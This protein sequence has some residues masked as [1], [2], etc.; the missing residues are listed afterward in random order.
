[1]ANTKV[2]GDLIAS[3]TIATGNIADNAVTSDKISGITTAHITEGSNLYYTD[4]RADARVALIV[5]SS[6][7]TLNTL[8]ELAA[9]LGDDPNY[10]A[11]TATTIGLKAP[12][13][14]PSFTGDVG[15]VT[16]HSSGKFAVMS[17]SVHGSY[18]FYNNGTSY[19]NGAVIIDSNITQ[20]GA[21]IASFT[22]KVGVG[23]ADPYAFDTTATK[24][25]VKNPGSAGSVVEVAR[26][27][28]S[29]DADGS[30]AVVRIGTSNDRGMYFQAGRTGSVPYGII[31]TTEY[32]GAK[33]SSIYLQNT[34]NVGIGQAPS[35]FANWRIFEIK[36][37]SN[38][39]LINFEN[40]SSTRTGAIAMN[41]ASSLMRF[42]T[43]TDADITFEANNAERMRVTGDG[44]VGIAG[45]PPTNGYTASGGG[46]KMLQIG[47]SSQIAAYGTDDEIGIFQNTYLNS[48][49][50]FQAITSNVAGSSIIL[51]DGK[52]YFK[53]AATSGTA[54][55]T[56][57]SMF[58][59][60]TG[61]VGI[62]T[63]SPLVRLQ[64]ERTVSN[65]TSRTAPVNL[66]YLTSEHPSVG[67]TGF[68]TAIAHYSRTYQNSTK[69]EQSKIA[70]T[71]Q[72]DS[73]STSGS[74]ID[75]YTK[76]LSTGS[77]APEFRM[78]I[79]YNGNVGIGTASPYKK[80][81]VV[82]DLQLD[83]SNANMW[84][85]SGAAGTN[86]FINWTFNSDDTVYNKIGIDYDTRASTGFHIDT[87]YP[88]TLDCTTYIDF[89]RSGGTLGRWNSTGLGIGTTSPNA[90]L[91]VKQGHT[92]LGGTQNNYSENVFTTKLGGYGVLSTGTDRYGSYGWLAFNSNNNYTGGAR[93]F[94]FTNGYKANEFAL[95][96]GTS[97]QAQ[98]TLGATGNVA[99][100]QLVFH[101][102]SSADFMFGKVAGDGNGPHLQ[103]NSY[104]YSTTFQ[105][106]STANIVTYKTG[107]EL[108]TNV[109]ALVF[110]DNGNDY[111]G[112]ITVNGSTNTTSYLSASDYRLKEDLKDFNGIDLVDKIPVYN[113]KWKKENVRTFGVL[114]HEL[115]K[116]LPLVV[117][118]DKD[119]EKYQ[120]VDYSK[121]VPVL[122]KAIQEL[123]AEIELLKNK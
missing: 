53:R 26:F 64:L 83:A 42:Q 24:F 95:L 22:D 69:T 105:G 70:F 121:I 19:F 66:I 107:T 68:G 6:P 98:P 119:E 79:N 35:S 72:G 85:K 40:S 78:R 112:Q 56:S 23:T 7:S 58:I 82:G 117:D 86:G 9:A 77:V 87:G 36:G 13:A 63:Y 5:D 100:G 114:A 92:I 89:K 101:V 118:G 51:V 75:F 88:L 74:T 115:K 45:I 73:V 48:S 44:N 55:T 61:N 102:N 103:V 54:Q 57:T 12:L 106:S 16:G 34:G 113:F 39:S 20:T 116:V 29:S 67:Y 81:E 80:L 93:P 111:C 38:G 76:T 21:T 10:A 49:G 108:N 62:G 60:T 33:T 1:M 90:K 41:D 31:G 25:H 120:T 122:I 50:V 96:M 99:N 110:R 28:G 65:A 2:T 97:D 37:L 46:W 123:K 52:I 18:D 104:G 59:D 94:A 11:T 43:M 109:G 71:Q 32:N 15:M 17:T 91:E 4:A 84:I 30:G 3:S 14:S 27:E 47:Q 8:N